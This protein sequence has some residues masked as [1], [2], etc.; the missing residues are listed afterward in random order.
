MSRFQIRT[1]LELSISQLLYPP[2]Q[3]TA[4]VAVDNGDN[5]YHPEVV[6]KGIPAQPPPRQ[7]S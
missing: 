2:G 1:F 5:D 3:E 4:S 6:N 7:A